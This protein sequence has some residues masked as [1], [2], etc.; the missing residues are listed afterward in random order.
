MKH[1]QPISLIEKC[2]IVIL[3]ACAGLFIYAV[4]PS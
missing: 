3:L 1:D 2:L 4:W